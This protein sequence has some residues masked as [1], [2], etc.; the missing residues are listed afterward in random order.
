VGK[1]AYVEPE[2]HGGGYRFTVKMG[3]P[4]NAEGAKSGTKLARANFACLMSG[5]PVS[6]DYIKAEAMAGRMGVRLMAIVAEGVRGRIYLAPTPE[7]E[8]AAERAKPTWRPEGE[9]ATRMTGGNCTP[10]GLRIW[11][12]LF[13]PRQLVALTTFSDLVQEA[14]ERVTCDAISI[15]VFRR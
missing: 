4:K 10:Y 6:G 14:R 7:H 12:D 3:K 1:E 2:I 9:I 11:G 8:A 13:T 15:G 5:A